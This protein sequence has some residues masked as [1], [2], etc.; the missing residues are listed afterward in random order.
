MIARKAAGRWE[1]V[2]KPLLALVRRETQWVAG[3]DPWEVRPVHSAARLT[4]PL[5]LAHGDQ[6]ALIPVSHLHQLAEAAGTHVKMVMEVPGGTHGGVFIAGG[7][8]LWGAL[9]VFFVRE[10]GGN[11]A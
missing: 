1:G 10:L 9:A 4:C 2:G 11:G 8:A 7:D 5:F 6:D 3:F